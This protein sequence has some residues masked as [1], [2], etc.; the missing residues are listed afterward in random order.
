MKVLAAQGTAHNGKFSGRNIKCVCSTCSNDRKCLKGFTT[1]P[2]TDGMIG[3]TYVI[4]WC[5]VG[6]RY[7]NMTPV[8]TF[9]L[10]SSG[11]VYEY[12]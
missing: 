6:V 1:A 10:I 3:V 11:H 9:N 8:D 7:D 12:F 5:A 2:E 4:H